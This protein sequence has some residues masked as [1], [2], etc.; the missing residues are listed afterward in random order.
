MFSAGMWKSENSGKWNRQSSYLSNK[1]HFLS[2]VG[3]I[4][5][6]RSFGE[7][8]PK[9]S[10]IP[11]FNPGACL[12]IV[13]FHLMAKNVTLGEKILRINYLFLWKIMMIITMRKE[14]ALYWKEVQS[15]HRSRE[16]A[17][18]YHQSKP[19]SD[20]GGTK[21]LVIGILLYSSKVL[22]RSE[23]LKR[24]RPLPSHILLNCYVL[25][26]YFDEGVSLIWSTIWMRSLSSATCEA[27]GCWPSRLCP[28]TTCWAGDSRLGIEAFLKFLK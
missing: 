27:H 22:F 13:I 12:S 8:S 19:H 21:W 17:P 23:P 18:L 2:K 11:T 26:I 15:V 20:S 3:S 1:F 14:T 10:K 4:K 9:N 16:S 28:S 25:F 5:P 6:H 24:T 7:A